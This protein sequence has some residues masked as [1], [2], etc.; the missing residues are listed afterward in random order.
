VNKKMKILLIEG[1]KSYIESAKMQ[2][3]EH[4]LTIV[5]SFPKLREIFVQNSFSSGYDFIITRWNNIIIPGNNRAVFG[6]SIT[7]RVLPKK[8]EKSVSNGTPCLFLSNGTIYGCFIE[9]WDVSGE[10]EGYCAGININVIY[11]RTSK[12]FCI[13]TN[14]G[15][16]KDWLRIIK[17]SPWKNLF[18]N[19]D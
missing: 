17:Q 5:S 4:E 16:G 6:A 2:F 9:S 19:E 1:K 10:C 13:E 18:F 8:L 14:C 3:N 7:K 12:S 15:K 11:E